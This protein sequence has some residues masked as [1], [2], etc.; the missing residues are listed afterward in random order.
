MEIRNNTVVGLTYELKISKEEDG[1][2]SAPFSVEIR[3]GEDPFYFLY[4]NSG[5]PEKFEELLK[6]KVKG[7]AFN[8]TILLEEAY[9]PTDDEMVMR[10]GKDQ[11]SE[12]R[13]FTEEMLVE[14]NFLP[15]VDEQGNPMQAKVLNVM[16]S[17]ILLDFNH[18]LVGF[19]LHFEG[20]IYEVRAATESEIE[21]G[22]VHGEDDT[23]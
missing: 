15:L 5:L 6:G 21:H 11:F 23:H 22:H 8:F 1:V 19:D 2:A 3:D 13:G 17:E 14:G 12:E 4:G 10:I 9:G 20:E 16:E 7:E 18:P